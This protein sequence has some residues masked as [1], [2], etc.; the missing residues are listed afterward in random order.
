MFS[1][2]LNVE[3]IVRNNFPP[4]QFL[5]KQPEMF[6][7][8]FIQHHLEL[9]I[10]PQYRIGPY[11]IGILLGYQL[12]RYQRIPVKPQQSNKYISEFE[13]IFSC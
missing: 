3:S 13:F 5:W 4:T 9:Y 7:P 10:K 6:N 11:L 8:N 1:A 12:A 2:G